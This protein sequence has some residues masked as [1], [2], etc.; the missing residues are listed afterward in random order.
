MQNPTF[1]N[2]LIVSIEEKIVIYKI[3]HINPI[4]TNNKNVYTDYDS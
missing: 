2:C 1:S 3:S 4:S